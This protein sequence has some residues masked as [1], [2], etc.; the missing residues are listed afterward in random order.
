MLSVC[1]TGTCIPLHPRV[2]SS[3]PRVAVGLDERL[4]RLRGNLCRAPSR[5]P[6]ARRLSADASTCAVW[7]GKLARVASESS[8]KVRRPPFERGSTRGGNDRDAPSGPPRA[9]PGTAYTDLISLGTNLLNSQTV[10]IKFVSRDAR[11]GR[12]SN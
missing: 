4:K 12:S 5:V 7:E 11:R 6:P 10:A 2:P 8:L 9:H 3:A 1:T